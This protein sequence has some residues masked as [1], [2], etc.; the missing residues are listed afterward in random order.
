[1]RHSERQKCASLGRVLKLSIP[2]AC[3]V[4]DAML[5][6]VVAPVLPCYG[7]G[8]PGTALKDSGALARKDF[9][10]LLMENKVSFY[11]HFIMMLNSFCRSNY[12]LWAESNIGDL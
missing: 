12:I 11:S 1:M 8:N 4:I 6:A 3:S 10:D 9:C 7:L 2:R 5:R